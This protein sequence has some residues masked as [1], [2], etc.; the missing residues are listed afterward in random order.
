MD[1][2][3]AVCLLLALAACGPGGVNVSAPPAE[4][5]G[6]WRR[7]AVSRPPASETP[8]TL[9]QL[10]ASALLRVPYTRDASSITVEAYSFRA[11]A[12]AFEAR[13]RYVQPQ[14][15][16]FYRGALFVVARGDVAAAELAGFLRALEQSWLGPTR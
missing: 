14:A 10:G 12:A 3:S 13:Q 5:G 8:E 1:R 4:V 15:A 7:G 6:G 2:R 16:A 9:R 11:E